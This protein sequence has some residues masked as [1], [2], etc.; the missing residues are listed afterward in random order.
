MFVSQLLCAG[1]R[2]I[3]IHT[4]V[5][6]ALLYY[7]SF[8]IFTIGIKS[9]GPEDNRDPKKIKKHLL[10]QF[11]TIYLKGWRRYEAL[12]FIRAHLQSIQKNLD[13]ILRVHMF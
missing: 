12:I 6:V 7:I 1:L 5:S 11:Q 3:Q 9:K 13:Y 8:N 4:L 2:D 10:S